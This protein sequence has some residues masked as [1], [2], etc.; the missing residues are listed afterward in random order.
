M[1]NQIEKPPDASVLAARPP[2]SVVVPIGGKD[3]DLEASLQLMDSLALH[4]DDELVIADNRSDGDAP[5]SLPAKVRVVPAG[6]LASSYHARNL[7]IEAARN[8][9]VLLL[10]GDCRPASD[11]IEGYFAAPISDDVGILAGEVR[12]APEQ[13]SVYARH[14]RARGHLAVEP[15]LTKGPYPAGVTANLMVRKSACVAVGGFCEVRSGADLDFCWRLQEDGWLLEYRP[16]AIVDHLHPEV[17]RPMLRKAAR[18]G[19]G[20]LWL[21]RRFPDYVSRP[22]PVKASVRGFGGA[23]VRLAQ[24]RLEEARF[25]ILDALWEISYSTG[26][27]VGTNRASLIPG[28]EHESAS[29]PAGTVLVGVDAFPAASETF[30]ANE[31]RAMREAG[32]N[33]RVASSLR[34]MRIDR[35]AAAEVP[36]DYLE[37]DGILEKASALAWLALRHPIRSFLDR[38]RR[39]AWA[40][41]EDAWPLS[42][43]APAVRR[44]QRSGAPH[45]HVHFAGGT[46]LNA[47]RMTRLV[48][49]RYSVTAHAFDIYKEPRNLREKLRGAQ[50]VTGSCEYTVRH[51]REIVGAGGPPVHKMVMGVDAGFFKRSGPAP[52]AGTVVAIGRLVEKKGFEYLIRAA[53]EL[54]DDRALGTV[55][56]AGDG[57]LRDSL[58]ALVSD[59]GLTDKVKF[60]RAWGP[61]AV[62]NLLREADLVAMPCV[63]AADGDRDSMPVV[64][65]EALAMEVPVV[66]SDEVGMPEMVDPSWGLLVPPRDHRALAAAIKEILERGAPTRAE[67][68]RRG[69]EF[70]ERE[71]DVGTETARLVGWLEKP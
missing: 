29:Q 19:P 69:R 18:Y 30:I 16:N 59:L 62:R 25:K 55:L 70:V 37:D 67:M 48:G 57:E 3:A 22:R 61:H 53:D 9:W 51:L 34:P 13:P 7:G 44:Y 23:V 50:F 66:G 71:C 38:R 6:R 58:E 43:L 33:V 40:T 46:A 64:V 11:L 21:G 27:I 41:E 17:L 28:A 15:H 60:V 68:G 49:G 10:D 31:I 63:V 54:R 35:A 52:G 42:A 4:D 5:P 24:G 39:R 65:K 2:V 8:E 36:A 14:A 1:A 32:W 47:L 12:G 20:Q 56:I 45:L 26:Y